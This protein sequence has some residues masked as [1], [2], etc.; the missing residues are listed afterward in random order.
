MC[1]LTYIFPFLS[2]SQQPYDTFQTFNF[3][4]QSTFPGRTNGVP[5]QSLSIPRD[6][7]S[8]YDLVSPADSVASGLFSPADSIASPA[9]SRSSHC[10]PFTPAEALTMTPLSIHQ[11]AHRAA[12]DCV[13]ENVDGEQQHITSELGYAGYTGW[14]ADA[15]WP[16]T[17]EV[18]LADDFDLSSIPPIELGTTMP[19][20]NP[21]GYDGGEETP[22]PLMSDAYPEPGSEQDP[23]A[24]LFTSY[25]GGLTW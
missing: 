6:S 3:D 7:Q 19:D 12:P 18:L 14:S 2:L 9:S 22:Y 17:S 15:L 23:F 20:Q 4:S 24:H 21:Q 11:H 5:L 25:G 16:D 13:P 8:S 1:V 10:G